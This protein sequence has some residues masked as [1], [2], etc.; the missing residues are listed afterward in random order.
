MKTFNSCSLQLTLLLWIGLICSDCC[1]NA[2]IPARTY[3]A[4]APLM[5]VMNP[6]DT[7]ERSK[8]HENSARFNLRKR[9][10]SRFALQVM[11]FPGDDEDGSLTSRKGN[12][13]L[14]LT[15]L[16]PL[17]LVYISN[18]WSRSSVY[19]LVNFADGA[20]ANTAMNVDLGF[21]EAQYGALASVAFTALFAIASLFAGNLADKYDRKAMTV[22][23]C[24]I[25][26][27]ATLGTGF[28]QDYDQVLAARVVMGLGAAFTTPVCM[29]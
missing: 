1:L 13:F 27:A 7:T 14:Y 20:V 17:L 23:A 26:S 10:D 12:P 28:A 2:F 19:Y 3:T 9:R 15:V 8:Y 11:Q 5:H 21:S 18:Q 24:C 25:W 29:R 6:F 4:S 16:N 22:A